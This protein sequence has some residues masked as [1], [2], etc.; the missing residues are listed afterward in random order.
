MN[1]GN[2]STPS[3]LSPKKNINSNKKRLDKE[4][5]DN[6]QSSTSNNALNSN[7]TTN[8]FKKYLEELKKNY[9][10]KLTYSCPSRLTDSSG[11]KSNNQKTNES[12]LQSTENISNLVKKIDLMDSNTYERSQ[13]SGLMS[14]KNE[15][16]RRSLAFDL[17]NS[18]KT[19]PKVEQEKMSTSVNPTF[20][21]Q[22][23]S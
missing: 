10:D 17:V 15:N 6:Y 5:I 18:N 7:S 3:K 13:E 12:K 9:M 14:K 2:K 22:V 21:E 1:H 11:I 23:N 8:E 4:E 16:V 19:T 20:S